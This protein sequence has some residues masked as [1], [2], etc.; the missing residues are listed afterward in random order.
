[1][2]K[3]IRLGGVLLAA[4]FLTG[5]STS[6]NVLTDLVPPEGPYFKLEQRGLLWG[7]KPV[8]LNSL[9]VVEKK[10][11]EWDYKNPLWAVSL[12]PGQALTVGKVQYGRVPNGFSESTKPRPLVPGTLYQVYGIGAGS[13]GSQQFVLK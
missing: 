2:G 8:Q 4:I 1:M 7:E 9:N 13:N 5:M 11:G 10:D 3:I 6:F 12:E